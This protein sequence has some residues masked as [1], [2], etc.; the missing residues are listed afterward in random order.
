[1]T[2]DAIDIGETRI[3]SGPEVGEEN[4]RGGKRRRVEQATMSTQT[5]DER[6]DTFACSCQMARGASGKKW[7]SD[8]A[9]L[10]R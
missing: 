9:E 10:D 6:A 7:A 2:K 8:R 5:A 1:M 3:R 4:E